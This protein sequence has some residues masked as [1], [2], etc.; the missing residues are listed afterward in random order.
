[1]RQKSSIALEETSNSKPLPDR[2][3]AS[4]Q[5]RQARV[6]KTL[7]LVTVALPVLGALGASFVWL[8][9]TFFVG[10]VDIHSQTAFHKVVVVAFDERGKATTF[11]SGR[12]QLP[13]GDYHLEVAFDAKP[14]QPAEI[15]VRLGQQ[16]HVEVDTNGDGNQIPPPLE[17]GMMVATRRFSAAKN[18]PKQV[19]DSV[20]TTHA[21][22]VA[23]ESDADIDD[24]GT[25]NSFDMR[26]QIQMEI[27]EQYKKIAKLGQSELAKQA[28][29]RGGFTS[30]IPGQEKNHPQNWWRI[31][32][33][34]SG[35]DRAQM[36]YSVV[37]SDYTDQAAESADSG[38]AGSGDN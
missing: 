25:T 27:K 6:N 20:T 22:S 15:S 1:M 13:P 31:W 37:Q 7:Q 32:N 23:A 29:D 30:T 8:W 2:L 9:N 34:F 38:D 33:G 19:L 24:E 10:D 16:T 11:N 26:K 14:K 18:P 28:L 5:S 36:D 21:R 12:F 17:N 3:D 35:A 4:D